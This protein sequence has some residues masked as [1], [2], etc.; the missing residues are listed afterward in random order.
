MST[1]R[2]QQL[3]DAFIAKDQGPEPADPLEFVDQAHGDERDALIERIDAY[4]ADAPRRPVTPEQLRGDAPVPAAARDAAEAVSRSVFGGGGEWPVLLPRLRHQARI[5]RK[6][7]VSDLADRLGVAADVERVGAYYHQMERGLLPEAGVSD[8]VLA[9]LASL[10][11]ETAER[12]RAAGK[13]IAPLSD[14][15]GAPAYARAATPPAELVEDAM[16]VA[17][18]APAR[19]VE[20][21]LVD[22]LFTGGPSGG[23][24]A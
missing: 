20:R 23:T 3:L 16:P 17:A 13:A 2:V 18:A 9:A 22:E 4:L 8:R 21:D 1:S 5:A 19:R 7:L 12:L 24:A 11:G 10:L 14:A 15:A 6:A